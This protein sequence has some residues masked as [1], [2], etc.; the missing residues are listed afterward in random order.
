MAVNALLYLAKCL[1]LSE[2][3]P[4]GVFDWE[5][6][7]KRS[8]TL[9]TGSNPSIAGVPSF[10]V[11]EQTRGVRD[12]TAMY[13]IAVNYWWHILFIGVEYKCEDFPP[14]VIIITVLKIPGCIIK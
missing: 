5:L 9:S 4:F 3:L 6:T 8:E 10:P 13:V 7:P 1:R 14:S 11:V 2:I 12:S